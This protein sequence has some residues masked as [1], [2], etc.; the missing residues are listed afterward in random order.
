MCKI[1]PLNS[2]QCAVPRKKGFRQDGWPLLA[3]KTIR[4]DLTPSL[5]KI[6]A[7]FKKDCRYCIRKCSML[8]AQCS[9]NNFDKFYELWRKA[10]KIKHLWV[11]PK[12]QYEA[13]IQS[14]GKNAFCITVKELAG[15]MVLVHDKTAYYYYAASL[16][17]GKKQ[18][19]P[20]SSVW[21]LMKE[22]KKRGCKIWDFE[23]IY[24]Q[25]WPNRGIKGYTHF[26]KSF[27]GEEIEFP[28]SFTRWF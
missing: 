7:G 3:T 27:G 13:L 4:I 8:N 16:S 5:D 20:Y 1:E 22:A 24:D 6:L 12:W 18:Q 11:P 19:L 2:A 14:F 25:R 28:G 15:A 9:M 17:E 21:E 23:G 10:A 26:K